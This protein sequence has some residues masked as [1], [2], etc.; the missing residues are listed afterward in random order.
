MAPELEE[1]VDPPGVSARDP[2]Q[3]IDL[4]KSILMKPVEMRGIHTA[5][6]E[7]LNHIRDGAQ[8]TGIPIVVSIEKSDVLS[9]GFTYPAIARSRYAQV[10]LP[11]Q[12][13]TRIIDPL[14]APCPVIGRTVID[15]DNFQILLPL[16]QY[17]QKRGFDVGYL[18]VQRDN[19]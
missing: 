8:I 13:Q 17:G 11:Y 4:T 9:S 3:F 2:P 6:G 7:L 12:A 19:D 16:I 10:G 15:N 14:D 1:P 5:S 18:V